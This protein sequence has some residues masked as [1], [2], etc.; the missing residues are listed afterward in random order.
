[1]SHDPFFAYLYGECEPPEADFPVLATL[2]DL[3]AL[4]GDCQRAVRAHLARRG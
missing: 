2:A 1:V 3:A 4:V